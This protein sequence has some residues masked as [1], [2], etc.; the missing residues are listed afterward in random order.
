MRWA[1]L[2]KR[3]HRAHTTC[4]MGRRVVRWGL[5]IALC[6]ATGACS[7]R[8][9]HPFGKRSKRRVYRPAVRSQPARPAT[10]PTPAQNA[11]GGSERELDLEI[12]RSRARRVRRPVRWDGLRGRLHRSAR[13]LRRAH[14]RDWRKV[15]RAHKRQ[16]RALKTTRDWRRVAESL[17][18]RQ[19]LENRA[20]TRFHNMEWKQLQRYRRWRRIPSH[21]RPPWRPAPAPSP[22]TGQARPATPLATHQQT[23]RRNWREDVRRKMV[24]A[25]RRNE[26]LARQQRTAA[27]NAPYR[28]GYRAKRPPF[29]WGR[30]GARVFRRLRAFKRLCRVLPHPLARVVCY[31][32]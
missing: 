2:A 21:K 15:H 23:W 27:T 9:S 7:F 10:R 19:T 32:Y 8:V 29:R 6:T 26:E 28:R 31:L 1:L 18:Q 20:I 13:A 12:E 4:V 17:R 25:K 14:R 16:W 30:R 22:H 3:C 5:M 11:Q 24:A